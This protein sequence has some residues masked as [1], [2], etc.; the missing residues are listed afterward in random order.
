VFVLAM[1][2]AAL[3]FRAAAIASIQASI[4]VES[5]AILFSPSLTGAGNVLSLTFRQSWAR[6]YLIPR[7]QRSSRERSMGVGIWAGP[8]DWPPLCGAVETQEPVSKSAR[9]IP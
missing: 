3:A 8:R 5:H 9:I 4:S 7:E 6:E 2:H 1:D